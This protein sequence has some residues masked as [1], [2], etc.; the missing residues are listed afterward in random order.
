[1]E[2][3]VEELKFLKILILAVVVIGCGGDNSVTHDD[4]EDYAP[5]TTAS[6]T[7]TGS[8]IPARWHGTGQADTTQ[9][10]T[11]TFDAIDESGT[12]LL[13]TLPLDIEEFC[14]KYFQLPVETRKMFWVYFLSAMSELESGHNP[15]LEYKEKFRNSYGYYVMSR[16]LLQLSD[17]SARGYGCDISSEADLHDPE[18]NLSCGV[19]ILD[20]WIGKDQRIAGKVNG[21]WQG[22]AR[23]WS[24]LRDKRK[25]EIIKGWTREC[26]ICK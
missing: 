13:E 4:S 12:N 17:E 25:L 14:P 20:R 7:N 9:W 10:T 1:V 21:K 18:V 11:L 3:V 23:Y 16:G 5:F 2:N 22:A 26:E 24:V 8:V 15:E 6:S 19:R